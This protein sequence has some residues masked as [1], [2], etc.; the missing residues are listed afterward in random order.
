SSGKRLTNVRWQP[1]RRITAQDLLCR[2]HHHRES[3]PWAGEIVMGGD[4]I[5]D[6][7]IVVDEKIVYISLGSNLGDRARMIERAIGAL[8]SADIRVTR[9]SS[10]YI[11]EPVQAP[12][13]PRFLNAVVEAGTS[14]LP[15]Q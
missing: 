4:I 2:R 12:G 14:L 8:N 10:L 9:Q 15:L 11:T 6:G 5:V 3:S 13:Q 1:E 7:D